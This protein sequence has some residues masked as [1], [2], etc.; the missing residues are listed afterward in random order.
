MRLSVKTIIILLPILAAIFFAFRSDE[1]RRTKA[2]AIDTYRRGIE[3]GNHAYPGFLRMILGEQE[4]RELMNRFDGE[5]AD[6]IFDGHDHSV[7]LIRPPHAH[8]GK[9]NYG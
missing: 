5:S 2:F 3:Q 8:G 6:V 7:Q 1:F 4:C 9:T